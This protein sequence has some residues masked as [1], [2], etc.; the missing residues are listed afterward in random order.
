VS[1]PDP[2]SFSTKIATLGGPPVEIA[3]LKGA[4]ARHEKDKEAAKEKKDSGVK[5]RQAHRAARRR[6]IARRAA[7]LRQQAAQQ[8]L[9]P[10]GQPTTPA[11]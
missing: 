11:R 5:K 4:R 9:N 8:Q 2:A 6:R 3:G 7:L 1:A 10:F